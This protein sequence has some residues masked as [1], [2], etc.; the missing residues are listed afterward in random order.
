MECCQTYRDLASWWRPHLPSSQTQ[1]PSGCLRWLLLADSGHFCPV[2]QAWTAWLKCFNFS[3]FRDMQFVMMLDRH[4]ALCQICRTDE[5][6]DDEMHPFLYAV[7]FFMKSV[8]ILALQIKLLCR[9]L[10]FL[11]IS[12]EAALYHLMKFVI[13][14]SIC[15]V[16]CAAWSL[17]RPSDWSRGQRQSVVRTQ[18]QWYI[19]RIS[20]GRTPLNLLLSYWCRQNMLL[21]LNCHFNNYGHFVTVLSISVCWQDLTVGCIVWISRHIVCL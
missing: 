14:I 4:S 3:W 15:I 12:V 13:S 9:L 7:Q 8:K 21:V 1:M 5:D 11:G 2:I 6:N 20:H 10:A 19:Q 17:S 18:K 16:C